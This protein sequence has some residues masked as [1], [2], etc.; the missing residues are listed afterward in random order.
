MSDMPDCP[1]SSSG[2]ALRSGIKKN[3]MPEDGPTPQRCIRTYGGAEGIDRLACC[4]MKPQAKR[5]NDLEHGS[6]FW[7]PFTRKRLV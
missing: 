3:H 1:K 7:V 2:A 6:K 4:C 5:L